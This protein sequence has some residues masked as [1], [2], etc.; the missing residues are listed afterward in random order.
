MVPEPFLPRRV[1]RPCRV[2]R[3]TMGDGH[4]VVVQSMIT[5]ETRNVAACV[6]QI[7][8]LHQAGSEIVRVTTPTLGE[9]Q[10]LEEI[11][12]RV[13]EKYQDVPMTAD[14][15]HQGSAIAVEAAKYVDEIRVNPGLFVF[16]RHGTRSQEVSPQESGEAADLR[17]RGQ[18]EIDRLRAELAYG[19]EEWADE[20]AAIEES[21][22]PVIE[23][24]K[25]HDRAMRVGVNHGS[26]SERL[27]V[28]YGDTPEGMVESALEYL[29]ICEKHGFENLNVSAKASRVPVKIAANRLMARR[30]DEEGLNYPL[31]LGV[32]EAGDGPYARVKSTA[33]IATLLME[34]I[35]DTIRVSLSEDPVN[36]IPVCYEILQ[37][38]GLRKTQVEYI[39]CPSCGRTKFDLPTVLREVRDATKHLV[40]LDIAVMGCI[41]NGPGEM[42]DA[43]YGYVGAAG[44]K[45]TL[46][47][48]REAVKHGIP[49]EQGVAELVRLLKEDGRWAEPP[50][51]SKRALEPLRTV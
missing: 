27:L 44:G 20:L 35:G 50:E 10:C 30:M 23:A 7:I 29:R 5:E 36:E 8:A 17:G 14:V 45:I 48:K 33:G 16:K 22:V 18:G 12:A 37:A 11:K 25:T 24:C 34:G 46:Y 38:C 2:G 26:L 3:V 49:Q 51:G 41:V 32:T 6:E 47:R 43:D 21:F 39:A 15:H 9:A 4:P 28:T 42:A 1:T 40:G 13:R 19:R 31:H